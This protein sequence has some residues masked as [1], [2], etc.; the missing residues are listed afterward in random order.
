M[1]S[2]LLLQTGDYL[3]L[4]TG[5][6]LLL[7]EGTPPEPPAPAT[8]FAGAAYIAA[9]Q[10]VR[11]QRVARVESIVLSFLTALDES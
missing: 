2:F 5:D 4:Q 7:A 3:L 1:G 10:R 6:K 8:T 9:A 11:A